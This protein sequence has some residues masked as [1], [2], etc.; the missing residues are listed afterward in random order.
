MSS[1]SESETT[2]LRDFKEKLPFPEARAVSMVQSTSP[3]HALTCTWT[4]CL[5]GS[6]ASLVV[7]L[8][9][10]YLHGSH[11]AVHGGIRRALLGSPAECGLVL[12]SGDGLEAEKQMKAFGNL[13]SIAKDAG[14]CQF[15]YIAAPIKDNINIA[16][17]R[18]PAWFSMESDDLTG[19]KPPWYGCNHLQAQQNLAYVQE[20]L[21]DMVSAG[22]P[23]HRIIVAGFSQGGVM[24]L[25]S[26]LQFEFPLGGCVVMSG[27][28]L[29]AKEQIEEMISKANTGL[30]VLWAH[31]I[32]DETW[33]VNFQ[34]AGYHKLHDAR[35]DIERFAFRGGHELTP[36]E[37]GLLAG[38]IREQIQEARRNEKDRSPKSSALLAR[39]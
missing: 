20:A 9:Y 8:V 10:F 14:P 24:A 3:L 37:A 34:S 12:V 1:S 6:A 25:M 36:T 16:G 31:G 33:P 15:K 19:Q 18:I 39:W 27:L 23:S 26:S 38:F 22:I 28:L 30:R 32:H 13:I 4:R 7:C 5:F 35:V 11:Y 29:G 17:K 21:Y 2:P